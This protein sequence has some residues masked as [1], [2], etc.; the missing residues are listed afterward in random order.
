MGAYVS[1]LVLQAPFSWDELKDLEDKLS[2][3]HFILVQ[4]LVFPSLTKGR[5][6][7]FHILIQVGHAWRYTNSALH[8]RNFTKRNGRQGRDGT[9]HR[10]ASWTARSDRPGRFDVVL[11]AAKV[12]ALHDAQGQE[13]AQQHARSL[14]PLVQTSLQQPVRAETL[15][16]SI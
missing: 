13:A 2:Q 6:Y 7:C 10:G 15:L 9:D 11:P 8:D 5:E 3:H 1:T 16:Q 12:H 14:S 4:S